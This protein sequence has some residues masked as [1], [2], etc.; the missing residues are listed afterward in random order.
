MIARVSAFR[1]ELLGGFAVTFGAISA[2]SLYSLAKD[3]AGDI[4]RIEPLGHS[5]LFLLARSTHGIRCSDRQAP[6]QEILKRTW[7]LLGS[8]LVRI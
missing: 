8:E 3:T 7:S 5:G 2:L 6:A 1:P 4:L